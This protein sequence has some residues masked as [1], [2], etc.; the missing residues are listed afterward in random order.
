MIDLATLSMSLHTALLVFKPWQNVIGDEGLYSFRHT[1]TAITIMLPLIM[2]SVA[3]AHHGHGY[4]AQLP[5]CALPVRPFW[6]RLALQWVPRYIIWFIVFGLAISVYCYV[7]GEFRMFSAGAVS[8]ST[9]A[10][11]VSHSKMISHT[12]TIGDGLAT[13]TTL[14]VND[15]TAVKSTP[16]TWPPSRR[17]S[18]PFSSM[19]LAAV[20][21][22]LAPDEVPKPPQHVETLGEVRDTNSENNTTDASNLVSRSDG[23]IMADNPHLTFSAFEALRALN[24]RDGSTGKPQRSSLS[25]DHSPRDQSKPIEIV[26]HPPTQAEKS[27]KPLSANL[28]GAKRRRAIIHQLRLLFVYPILYILLWLIPF[29][30]HCYQYSDYYAIH[31]PFPLTLLAYLSLAIMGAINGIVFNFKERPWRHISGSDGTFVGSFYWWK[32]S[33]RNTIIQDPRRGEPIHTSVLSSIIGGHSTAESGHRKSTESNSLPFA[34]KQGF[35]VEPEATPPSV[36]VGPSRT[37]HPR[38]HRRSEGQKRQANQAYER[39]AAE[40]ADRQSGHPADTLDPLHDLGARTG[41][42]IGRP[43]SNWWDRRVSGMSIEEDVEREVRAE[44]DVTGRRET[45]EQEQKRRHSTGEIEG[46]GETSLPKAP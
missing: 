11:N 5:I 9:S 13:D 21:E 40:M 44:Q 24:P 30:L 2:A 15:A 41:S 27:R 14:P 31:P 42:T 4:S 3:F 18:S 28:A 23:E 22:E 33:A 17:R 36:P 43:M 26:V 35:S 19:T 46:H 29:I 12:L 6:F 34:Q 7:G 38:R 20:N 37:V 16:N 25:S 1:V 32:W 45:M 8:S 39:L 10:L